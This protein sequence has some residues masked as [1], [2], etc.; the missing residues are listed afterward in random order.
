MMKR[1]VLL[2]CVKAKLAYPAKA[3]ELYVSDLF[4]KSYAYAQSILPDKVF[5]LSAKYGLIDCEERIEP[6]ELTLNTMG[7]KERMVWSSKV[8][9]QLAIKSDLE[10]DK[11]IFLAGERYRKYLLPS[12]KNVEIPMEGLRI[13]EQ[14]AWL[15]RM[16]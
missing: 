14:M 10:H 5:I 16:I 2:S 9:K 7:A 11:F 12:I 13:G 8:I 3:K 1:I 4:K 15:K 6:Y